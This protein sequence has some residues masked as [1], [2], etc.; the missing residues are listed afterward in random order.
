MI[1]DLLY[2]TNR[3]NLLKSRQTDNSRVIAKIK[4]KIKQLENAV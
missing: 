3:L 2:Y 1:R 4:R